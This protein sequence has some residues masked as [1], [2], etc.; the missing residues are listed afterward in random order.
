MISLLSLLMGL[1]LN[2]S[3]LKVS[4]KIEYSSLSSINSPLLL[5]QLTFGDFSLGILWFSDECWLF[6]VLLFLS[7]LPLLLL[8]FIL[9]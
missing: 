2:L 9:L 1:K 4:F 7:L 3:L 5:L 8:I 6:I